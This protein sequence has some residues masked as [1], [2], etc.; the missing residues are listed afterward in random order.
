MKI[1]KFKWVTLDIYGVPL[2]FHFT[3]KEAEKQIKYI[4][5][6]YSFLKPKIVK[7]NYGKT[8]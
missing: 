8:K 1:K 6:F 7:A 3:K 2:G 4:K 5:K